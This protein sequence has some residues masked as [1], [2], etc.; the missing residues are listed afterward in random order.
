M[1]D[2]DELRA[3]AE[4]AIPPKPA[5]AQ[6][7]TESL[8]PEET[9]KVLHELRVHQIELEMQNDE[10]RHA[11]AELDASRS[12]Y[13]DLYDLAPVGYCTLSE[14][15]LILEANL[16]A[17]TLL[18]TPRGDLVGRP[19]FRSVI[20][21]DRG[22][23][24][25]HL[26]RL[27]ETHEPQAFEF[28]MARK[29]GG[30][31]F[32]V[33]LDATAAQEGNGASTSRVTLTDISAI[34]QAEEEVSLAKGKLRHALDGTN[35]GIWDWNIQ[36]GE[37]SIDEKSAAL[38]GYTLAELEPFSFQTWM[39]L[40]HPGDMKIVDQQMMKHVRGETD[41][42]SSETRMRHKDGSWVWIQ[43][44]GKIID[45]DKD[46][47]PLR[48]FGTNV[49]ITERKLAEEK[50]ESL[51]AEK[52]LILKEVHHRIKNN[53]SS[54]HG[55]FA[56]QASVSKSPEAVA[57]LEAAKIRVLSMMV[58]YGKLFQSASF[59][60]ISLSDYLPSL[61]DDIVANFANSPSVRVEKKIDN[62]V[63]DVNKAQTLG[64]ILNELLTNIMK[65]AFADGRAGRISVSASMG[66]G[67]V[68]LVIE[69]DGVG[70]PKGVDF[71]NP[72]GFGIEL[73]SALMQ[74][75]EGAIRTER[76]NGTKIT[77]EFK[78]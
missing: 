26:Q 5:D 31:V 64:I 16:R 27:F 3:R 1:T 61:V 74:Q 44:R 4:G 67:S 39:S 14:K 7:D 12:R 46:G 28:R 68:R 76:G 13:F 53:M 22:K 58:I 19:L 55:I 38:L 29:P 17:A 8:S 70:L 63:L 60:S 25:Q 54:L 78:K 69:D 66:G 45:R 50:I 41:F 59:D 6:E 24:H 34:K 11:Q 57:A 33:R 56:L 71:G 42:Y 47:K 21:E 15:G 75:L 48:M 77:I 18:D 32:W 9:R 52:E 2:G 72:D 23:F 65:Y 43:G 30:E 73:V 35:A 40:K 62:V 37:A 36:S 51:V 20:T 49:D 10:L